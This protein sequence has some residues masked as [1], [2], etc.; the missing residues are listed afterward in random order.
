[1]TRVSILVN[2]VKPEA[3]PLA[4][5]A[6]KWLSQYGAEV[7]IISSD[8]Q[9]LS[10]D[11]LVE[12][13]SILGQADLVLALGGDGTILRAVHLAS[14]NETPVLGINL[15]RF[16]FMASLSPQNLEM[17][18]ASYFDKEYILEQRMMIECQT[19][20]NGEII[21]K[22]IALNEIVLH[23]EAA[24]GMLTLGV[25]IDDHQFVSFPADGV[26]VA[27]PTGSTAYNL[28]AG[29]PILEPTM[30]AMIV[31]AVSPHALGARPLVLRPEAEIKLKVESGGQASLLADGQIHLKFQTFDDVRVRKSNKNAHLI[32]FTS[33]DFLSKLSSRLLYGVRIED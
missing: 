3:R 7:K 2:A 14:T 6:V 26:I 32:T 15:G 4:D 19:L 9:K 23:R 20:R 21:D 29:G 24:G 22:A 33:T 12:E 17:G 16:G 28:S 1:M 30:R 13:E 18:L 5:R 31:T 8:A 10:A 27:T 25:S 11:D